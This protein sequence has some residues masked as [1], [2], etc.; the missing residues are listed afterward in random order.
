[1]IT[2]FWHLIWL[3]DAQIKGLKGTPPTWFTFGTIFIDIF[4]FYCIF[5]GA[6]F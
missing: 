6:N 4:S 1:M 2:I 3:M 5:F